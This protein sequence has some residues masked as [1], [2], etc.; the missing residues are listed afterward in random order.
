MSGSTAF[1][2]WVGTSQSAGPLVQ[3]IAPLGVG[4]PK[5]LQA[6]NNAG[7]LPGYDMGKRH[8]GG[9]PRIRPNK[10]E[11][12]KQKMML[13]VITPEDGNRTR[14]INSANKVCDSCLGKREE[15][16]GSKKVFQRSC[17]Q[18]TLATCHEQQGEKRRH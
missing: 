18:G 12:A 7:Y 3:C 8:F 4:G 1:E 2:G 9:V 14:Q 10:Q 6:Q 15:L 11:K 17:Q 5:L 13:V 16:R